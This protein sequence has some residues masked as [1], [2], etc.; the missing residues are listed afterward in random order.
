VV[1][2]HLEGVRRLVADGSTAD[3]C[4]FGRGPLHE[5]GAV[6]GVNSAADHRHLG[7]LLPVL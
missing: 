3:D 5:Q 4:A 1:I 6:L 2:E 7:N